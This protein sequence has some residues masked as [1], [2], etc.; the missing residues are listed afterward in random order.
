MRFAA[1]MTFSK[2]FLILI[3]FMCGAMGAQADKPIKL[4]AGRSENWAAIRLENE[5]EAQLAKGDIENALRTVNLALQR[6][7][8]LW[9][10]F[11]TR[12]KVFFLQ[13]KYEAVVQDCNQLLR[14]YTLFIEAALLRAGANA[15]LGRYDA[16][17]NELD[18]IVR[19]RP[20]LDSYAGAL[21]QRAWFLSTCP[22]PSFRNGQQ[23]IKDAMAA[24]R[25]TSWKDEDMIDTLAAAYAGAGDFNFAVRNEE[26]ALGI[27]GTDAQ[28]SKRFKQ[29]LALFRQHRALR[30]SQ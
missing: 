9:P 18:H 21:R 1:R 14:Q 4:F 5:A 12:A 11:Y 8:T 24:C 27:K 10:A 22:D 2:A 30:L 29:H 3:T 16:S 15:E 28:K 20:H 26:K 23:A 6:D 17:L 25:I 19:I 7:P 13:H